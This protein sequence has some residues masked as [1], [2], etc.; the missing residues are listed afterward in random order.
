MLVGKG[1]S[2][3][4]LLKGRLSMVDLLVPTSLCQ[5]ILELKILLNF[6][7]KQAPLM[8]R[9]TVMSLPL[10]LVFPGLSLTD[11][12]KHSECI[13]ALQNKHYTRVELLQ[14]KEHASFYGK[15]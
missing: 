2:R 11:R 14:R 7:T 5:L 3:D 10:Q 12:V 1:L 13:H 6:F 8:R 4:P 15:L 9:S